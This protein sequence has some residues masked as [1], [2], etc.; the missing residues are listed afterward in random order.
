MLRFLLTIF[1]IYLVRKSS[2][3]SCNL[4]CYSLDFQKIDDYRETCVYSSVWQYQQLHIL[5]IRPKTAIQVLL[6]LGGDKSLFD[7]F[8]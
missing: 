1:F 3:V 2:L 6:L 7:R 8:V 5:R 4:I